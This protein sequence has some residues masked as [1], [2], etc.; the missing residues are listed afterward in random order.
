MSLYSVNGV[1]PSELTERIR[2]P[3]GMT[4]TGTDGWSQ[5]E[6][7]AVGITGPYT[8]PDCDTKSQYISWNSETLT[9][10][11]LE[12]TY[13]TMLSEFLSQVNKMIGYSEVSADEILYCSSEKRTELENF[14]TYITGLRDNPPGTRDALIALPTLERPS[15]DS[16]GTDLKN[17][18][19]TGMSTCGTISDV[20][21]LFTKNNIDLSIMTSEDAN[22]FISRATELN[23]TS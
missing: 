8:I 18:V 20:Q 12:K 17:T 11:V 2:L 1:E 19:L 4:L 13:E 5:S 10:D 15:Y 16:L 3:N 14:Y 6:L 9:Y 21:D 23:I 7:N 22:S